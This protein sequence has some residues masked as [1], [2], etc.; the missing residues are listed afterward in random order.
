MAA[1]GWYLTL[2]IMLKFALMLMNK[3]ESKRSANFKRNICGANVAKSLIG[4]SACGMVQP[5][6]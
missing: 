3:G 2:M 1:Q 4:F 5:L 6:V